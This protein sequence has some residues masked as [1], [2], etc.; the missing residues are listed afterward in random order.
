LALRPLWA[1]S[2]SLELVLDGFGRRTRIRISRAVDLLQATDGKITEI[3]LECGFRD[4]STFYRL[5]RKLTGQTPADVR[6]AK[7]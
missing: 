6:R 4:L 3:A 2:V 7:G 1:R 5:F